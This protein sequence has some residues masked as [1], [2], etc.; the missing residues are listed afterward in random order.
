VRDRTWIAASAQRN[1]FYMNCAAVEIEDGGSSTLQDHPDMFVG[2]MVLAGHI[3]AGEC[4]TTGETNLEYPNPGPT[5]L[6]TRT[7]T[8][9]L[10][11]KKPTAGKCFAPGSKGGAAS[12]E[13]GDAKPDADA[14]K[15]G[16]LPDVRIETDEKA[17]TC[18]CTCE[19]PKKGR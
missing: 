13:G 6:V 12:G 4:A 7:E 1:E 10:P 17:G 8:E 15:K 18:K 5:E 19:L 9:G 3:K 16:L 2:D 11:F 14:A